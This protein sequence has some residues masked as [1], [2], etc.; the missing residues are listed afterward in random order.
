MLNMDRHRKLLK[1]NGGA[2]ETRTRDL[3]RDRARAT[4]NASSQCLRRPL[5]SY[6]GDFSPQSRPKSFTLS[7]AI[8][9]ESNRRGERKDPCL[10]RHLGAPRISS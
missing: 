1:V 8:K 2:D 6:L 9:Q 3:R 4:V 5:L 7:W 10:P